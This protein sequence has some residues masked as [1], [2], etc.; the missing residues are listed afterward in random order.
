MLALQLPITAIN[1]VMTGFGGWD[2]EGLGDTGETYLA[3]ADEQMRSVSR[4]VLE[5]PAEFAAQSIAAGEDPA[6]ADKA[7]RVKGTVLLQTT[8][9]EAVQNAL[10]RGRAAR[11]SPTIT[12]ARRRWSPTRHWRSRVCAG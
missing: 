3:G 6:M 2:A 12:W 4:L 7:A 1:D 11:S 10:P 9:T 5:D 8:S